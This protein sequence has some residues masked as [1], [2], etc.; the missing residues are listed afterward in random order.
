MQTQTEPLRAVLDTL[1]AR[2]PATRAA[3]PRLPG[4]ESVSPVGPQDIWLHEALL[5]PYSEDILAYLN[6]VRRRGGT[7]LDLGSGAGRLAVPFAR[8]GFRVDA[9]DRDAASLDRLHAWAARIGPRTRQSVTTV[10]ADL[11]LLKLRRSYDLVLLAGTMVSA[12][13]PAARPGL[14]HE[15]ASHLEEGGTLALDYTSHET[16][17]LARCP[18]RTHRFQVP[19]CDG[20]VEW[21]VVQQVFDT[22]AMT[23]R[24]TYRTERPADARAR[25]SA[26]TTLKWVVDQDA[27]RDEL[28]AA[29]LHITE[30]R[31][32]RLDRRTLSVFLACRT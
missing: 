22:G 24:I 7:V 30:R 20:V 6:L 10:Q 4:L 32:Q 31:Q 8:H 18:R 19:R 17:E 27:L 11:N 25:S 28:R 21:A 1:P 9:V 16:G 26:T 2:T 14:L 12:V 13:S 23:E 3:P 5:G 15:V 29:G